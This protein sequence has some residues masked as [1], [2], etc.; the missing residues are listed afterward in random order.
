[1][2]GLVTLFVFLPIALEAEPENA[3]PCKRAT[4]QLYSKEANRTGTGV[5]IGNKAGYYYALTS[6]H[7]LRGKQTFVARGWFDGNKESPVEFS[8]FELLWSEPE[9]DLACIRFFGEMT[10]I[11]PA[12]LALPRQ[13]LKKFPLNVFSIGWHEGANP[14]IVQDQAL[15]R[16]LVKNP[17]GWSG[18]FWQTQKEAIVGRSGG[19]LLNDQGHV[20]GICSGTQEGRGY[21][22]HLDE[23]RHSIR[24]NTR[25]SWL[26]DSELNK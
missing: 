14:T 16:K 9:P 1:M 22:T 12:K 8:R 17:K 25:T 20:I 24:N 2:T 19:P 26:L 21:Y 11:E 5:I 13:E 3:L 18:F 10:K 7:V 6:E 4:I 15:A 23:I